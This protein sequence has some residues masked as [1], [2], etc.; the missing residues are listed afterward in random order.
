MLEY[1]NKIVIIIYLIKMWKII[2]IKNSHHLFLG[3]IIN[4]NY[5]KI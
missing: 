4:V 2:F 5:R 1:L 3:I